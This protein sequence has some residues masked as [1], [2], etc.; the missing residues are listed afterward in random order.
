MK[1]TFSILLLSAVAMGQAPV[2]WKSLPYYC[3]DIKQCN[4]DDAKPNGL[5]PKGAS[6]AGARREVHKQPPSAKSNV[7]MGQAGTPNIL[8]G[9]PLAEVP[10]LAWHDGK[11]KVTA[12]DCANEIQ[13]R[14][15]TKTIKE[16]FPAECGGGA[17]SCLEQGKVCTV[18]SPEVPLNSVPACD[19]TLLAGAICIP[20]DWLT[21]HIKVDGTKKVISCDREAS[22]SLP[23]PA[24]H[25]FAATDGTMCAAED[26][27]N[28]RCDH[29]VPNS[30]PP[31]T[32]SEAWTM[33]METNWQAIA[34]HCHIERLMCCKSEPKGSLWESADDL[35]LV[36]K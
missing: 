16:L 12:T 3:S 13:F 7:A 15:V 1:T 11:F 30:V 27:H 5:A 20:P 33:N 31:A 17:L 34:D 4:P 25:Y 18:K 9:T 29:P 23:Y 21:Y 35:Q 32:K 2:D 10:M 19:G 8:Q 24:D 28:G 22:N 36:C 14:G 26:V 6:G